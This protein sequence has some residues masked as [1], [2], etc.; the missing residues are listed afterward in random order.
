MSMT[1]DHRGA[2]VSGLMQHNSA[3]GSRFRKLNMGEIQKRSHGLESDM[4]RDS[5]LPLEF[6]TPDGL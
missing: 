4:Q 2:G 6:P 3:Q 1:I 5:E